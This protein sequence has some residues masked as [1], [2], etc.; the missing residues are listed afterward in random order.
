[1]GGRGVK[2]LVIFCGGHKWMTPK[3]IELLLFERQ[4]DLMI[5]QVER[6]HEFNLWFSD[7]FRG[8]RS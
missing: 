5:V 4:D 1:M 7:D 8:N 6:E 2:K 3:I